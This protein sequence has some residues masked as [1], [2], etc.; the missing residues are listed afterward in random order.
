[1]PPLTLPAVLTPS[2]L[3]SI[4]AHPHLPQHTW[5]F[6]AGVTLSVLNRPDEIPKVFSYALEHGVDAA[7]DKELGQKELAHAEQL[8]IARKLRE[9]LVKSAAIVGLPKTINALLSLKSAT[10]PSLHDEPMAYSPSA[11]IVE[12]YDMPSS[13]ILQRGQRFFDKVYGKVSKRV[14]GQMDRSGTEDLG[15]VARLMYGYL[16]SNTR[17]LSPMESSFVLLAGLIPQDVNPQLKGHLKGAL[18]NGATVEE[19]RAVREIVIRICEASGMKKLPDDAPQGWG[20]RGEVAN[21]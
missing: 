5:Y 21:L 6:I 3:S 1:M 15:V 16:L 2:L 20:W 12:V 10:P 17:V 4:R 9:S 19:V 11:R 7:H 14:M 18:N 8:R 13:Q